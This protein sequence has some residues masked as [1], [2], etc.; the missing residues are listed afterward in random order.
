MNPLSR[1]DNIRF[2]LSVT[3]L[4]GVGIFL[5]WLSRGNLPD[6]LPGTRQ[7]E[8]LQWN[9]VSAQSSVAELA[10][11]DP[12]RPPNR[13]EL[14]IQPGKNQVS[15][16]RTV[17][18]V[19]LPLFR[20][21]EPRLNRD[22]TTTSEEG[23]DRAVIKVEWNS[24]EKLRRQNGGV[25]EIRPP[26]SPP[27]QAR[28]SRVTSRS[29]RNFSL[30]GEIL[31]RPEG[32]FVITARDGVL[33]ATIHDAD[34]E[35]N[36]FEIS[37]SRKGSQQIQKANVSPV[38]FSC[39]TEFS[40]F[41]LPKTINRD[42]TAPEFHDDTVLNA[43]VETPIIDVLVV[44]T[45]S[46][47]TLVGGT[48][49][50]LAAIDHAITETNQALVRSDA[51]VLVRL[52]GTR[53]ITY[54]SVDSETDLMRLHD[55]SDGHMDEIHQDRDSRGADVVTLWTER[56][57]G[58]RAYLAARTTMRPDNF[59]F[60]VCGIAPYDTLFNITHTFAHEF[61]HN[62]GCGHDKENQSSVDP[63]FPVA[64]GWR[65]LGSDNILYRSI[66][67]YEPGERVLYFSNPNV[68]FK[69]G[70]T[71]S[72]SANNAYTMTSTASLVSRFRNAVL[73][74]PVFELGASSQLLPVTPGDFTI[75][76]IASNDWSWEQGAGSEWLTVH[77]GSPLIGSHLFEYSVSANPL[78]VNRSTTITFKSGATI[79]VF[80]VTQERSTVLERSVLE[81]KVLLLEKKLRNARKGGN[82]N[83]IRNLRKGIRNA[84][85]QLRKL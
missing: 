25:L 46:A 63:S 26:S 35:G 23:T 51:F 21:V 12:A 83:I 68:V 52:A 2:L 42:A 70:A 67:A 82:P 31:G 15:G 40:D 53:R 32:R 33:L 54:N 1:R 39:G 65:W 45:E 48:S 74:E 75:Q 37:L 47:R 77:E 6:R 8:G 49:A 69:G 34:A 85:T 60:N 28:V 61:G 29:D 72:S 55:K 11:M 14:T 10:V 5:A 76:V 36:D 7:D 44:Y 4:L 78:P 27:F 22:S 79:A 84:I 62:M 16:P 58:G 24:L 17:E 18:E 19:A 3:A 56:N 9:A 38:P 30:S 71:G 66:M 73:N 59:A 50:M 20:L 81:R 41:L 57:Y 13:V 64:Y 43:F 80:H